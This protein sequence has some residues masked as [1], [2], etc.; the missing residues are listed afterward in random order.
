MELLDYGS[1]MTIFLVSRF[2]SIILSHEYMEEGERSL[3]DDL[4]KLLMRD[5]ERYFVIDDAEF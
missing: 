5:R 3:S 1:R 4:R 2:N